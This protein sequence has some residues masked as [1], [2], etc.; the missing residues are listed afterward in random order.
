[1]QSHLVGWKT[2]FLNMVGRFTLIKA[3]LSSMANHV[4]QFI[5][6]AIAITKH[7]DQIQ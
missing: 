6:M 4:M 3:T 2:K 5:M 1:M 7:I